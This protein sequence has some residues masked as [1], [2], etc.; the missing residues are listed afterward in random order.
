LRRCSSLGKS[1][2]SH[3]TAHERAVMET[4]ESRE[5]RGDSMHHAADSEPWIAESRLE[6]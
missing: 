6:R 3:R 2:T 5:Q 4:A 1:A